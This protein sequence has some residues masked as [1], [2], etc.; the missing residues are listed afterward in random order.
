MPPEETDKPLTEA[1]IAKLKKW[2]QDGAPWAQH[3]AYV[4]PTAHHEPR[5]GDQD[6]AS[7]WID[8]FLYQRFE[9]AGIRP[10]AGWRP[11]LL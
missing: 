10:A 3:W 5:T 11:Y 1:E 7:H 4:K 2:I 6:W 8:R 9:A